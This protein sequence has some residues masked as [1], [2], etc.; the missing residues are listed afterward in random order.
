MAWCSVYS[1]GINW[2]TKCYDNVFADIDLHGGSEVPETVVKYVDIYT[3]YGLVKVMAFAAVLAWI[4][5]W[6]KTTLTALWMSF[7]LWMT[8]NLVLCVPGEFVYWG[9]DV[10]TTILGGDDDESGLTGLFANGII[11][12]SGMEGGDDDG[13]DH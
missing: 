7:V 9:W 4:R 1:G 2:N 12:E 11:G 6:L 5:M 13:H 8:P 10:C 3:W